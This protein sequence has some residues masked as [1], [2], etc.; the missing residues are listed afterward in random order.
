ML[1]GGEGGREGEGRRGGRGGERE[2][3]KA[4]LNN[5]EYW[6]GSDFYCLTR[7]ADRRRGRERVWK[8]EEVSHCIYRNWKKVYTW[9]YKYFIRGIYD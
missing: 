5:G 1:T 8:S 4:Y 7:T 3:G 2:G 6:S 9:F